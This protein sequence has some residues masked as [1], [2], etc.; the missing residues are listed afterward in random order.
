[1]GKSVALVKLKRISL[2]LAQWCPHCVPLSLEMG[3]KMADDLQVPLRV[4]DID[5]PGAVK[6][7]DKLVL[8][9]GDYTEDYL[10]PQVFAEFDD[11]TIKHF[12]TGFSEGLDFTRRGW[13]NVFQSDF[14]RNLGINR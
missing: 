10:I 13:E 14:Y 11:G 3:Q 7:A 4:L 1:M 5:D 6:I 9:Y 8:D 2:V 12:L